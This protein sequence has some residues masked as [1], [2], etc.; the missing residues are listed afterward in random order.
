MFMSLLQR[1]ACR[2]WE[3]GPSKWRQRPG[4]GAFYRALFTPCWW[5]ITLSQTRAKCSLVIIVRTLSKYRWSVNTIFSIPH[6][7]SKMSGR[8]TAF[9][10]MSRRWILTVF[11]PK[12]APLLATSLMEPPQLSAYFRL[13]FFLSKYWRSKTNFMESFKTSSRRALKCMG[14]IFWRMDGLHTT[15]SGLIP[16]HWSYSH[17]QNDFT[18]QLGSIDSNKEALTSNLNWP[19]F[20]ISTVLHSHNVTLTWELCVASDWS[21]SLFLSSSRYS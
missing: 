8:P 14:N 10:G 2:P 16:L 15:C 7:L 9:L 13:Q 6:L 1:I 21:D 5:K 20:A 3:C 11:V 18:P 17:S 4:K 19:N 12:I